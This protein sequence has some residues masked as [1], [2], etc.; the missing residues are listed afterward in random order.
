MGILL[1]MLILKFE[2]NFYAYILCINFKIKINEVV[3][4]KTLYFCKSK[5]HGNKIHKYHKS[6]VWNVF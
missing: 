3:F 4:K 6:F 5:I 1:F 2:I